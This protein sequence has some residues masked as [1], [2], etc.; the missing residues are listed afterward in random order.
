MGLMSALCGFVQKEDISMA[1]AK[2]VVWSW[3]RKLFWKSAWCNIREE[4]VVGN[5]FVLVLS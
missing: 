5:I 4:G 2:L 3:N 1:F